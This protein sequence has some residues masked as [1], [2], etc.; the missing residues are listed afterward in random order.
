MEH[1]ILAE[2]A[3]ALRTARADNP[4]G[5]ALVGEKGFRLFFTDPLFEHH[6]LRP[7]SFIKRRAKH[8]LHGREADEPDVPLEFTAEELPLDIVD[9]DNIGDAAAST[10]RLFSRLVASPPM[11]N[12]AVRL[13]NEYLDVA[14]TKAASLNVGDVGQAFKKIRERLVGQ[15]IVLLIEDVALIQGV[16]RDLLDAI[17]EVGVVQGEEK[18]ATVRTLMAV[19]P[20][21]YRE[22]LPE[23]FRRRAEASSPSYQVDVDLNLEQGDG[24]Q[25]DML[26]DFFGRYLNAARVGKDALESADPAVPNGCHGCDYRGSCHATFGK[27]GSGD[28]EYG[29]YPYNRTAI[30]RAVRACA[31]RDGDRVHFNPR[32]VLSRAIRNTLNNNIGTIES[33]AFPPTGFLAT[34]SSEMGLPQ[35]PTHIRETI[36][37]QY[38]PEDSGRVVSLLT[39]WGDGGSVRVSDEI[40]AAFDHPSLPD[41]TFQPPDDDESNGGD[42]G[43]GGGD[44]KRSGVSA[45]LQ[46]QLDAIDKWS[47][48]QVLPQSLAS[49][50]RKIVREALIT[51]IDWFDT[52]IKDPDTATLA[53]AVPETAR[54]VS[55]EGANENLALVVPPL[56]RIERT[57]RN[58]MTLKGLALIRG[59]HPARAGDALARLDALVSD[60][61]EEAKRRIV[62]ELALDDASL[63]QAAASLIKGAA[64]C[65]MLPA[66]PKEIAY[67][68]A[69][70][71]REQ[72]QR[73]DAAARAPEW[74][75]AYQDYIGARTKAVDQLMA[76]M[77]AAQGT[78][79][80]YAIDIQRLI[81][82]VREA[83]DVAEA[84]EDFEVPPWCTEAHRRLK[85]LLRTN[86]RQIVH[87][88]GLI[89]RIRYQLP[90]D[91]TFTETVD[92][93]FEAVKNGQDLGRVP[94]VNMQALEASNG[95]ARGWDSGCIREV[96]RLVADAQEATGTAR[97]SILGAVIGADLPK[98]ADYFE[99]TSQWVEAGI[100]IAETRGGSPADVDSQ[101]EQTIRTWLEILKESSS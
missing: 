75:S 41:V 39:F 2:L 90:D 26:V 30:L 51:R 12:E 87:W 57:A 95:E 99:A 1:K 32:R 70:L 4:Y 21:Y 29:L 73:P 101:L 31:T 5:K 79:G 54:G 100:R 65:G 72:I 16:R 69:C 68:N 78:G 52:V 18:Y 48:G 46:K 60:S 86:G 66:K 53:K 61:V 91:V 64:A 13:L 74:V 58:A 40:V 83:K 81:L 20:S 92:A 8:A 36:E 34:E 19:T 43:R 62:A 22:Q 37:N 33:G 3:E 55:I 47:H 96:E 63:V 49:D 71:W 11:Q 82:I 9:N 77:G 25:E 89:D 24:D 44:Q 6:L 59:G 45:S 67:V 84:D 97:L 35:I 27:S 85:A 10:Q 23:T 76:G 38:S 93:I 50:I 7:G 80:V 94:V 28:A 88:Q 15:E 56:L 42:G 14:V 98:I 17:I